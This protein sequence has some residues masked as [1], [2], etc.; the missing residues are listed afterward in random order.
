MYKPKK[1][2]TQKLSREN[3][4]DPNKTGCKKL[5]TDYELLNYNTCISCLLRKKI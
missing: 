3:C 2:Y 4:K 5:L 1:K